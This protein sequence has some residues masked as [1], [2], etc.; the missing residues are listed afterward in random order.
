M[1]T[2][3]TAHYAERVQIGPYTVLEEIARGGHGMVYRAQDAQ[4]RV[5]AL[6]LLLAERAQNRQA[7]ERFQ[8]EVNALGRLRHPHV[9]SILGAGEHEGHPWLA[10]EFVEGESLE[11]RLR[12][13]PL[14]IH[15][16]IRVAQQLAQALSYVHACGVL[17]RDL[18]PGNVL[19]RG[20]EAMLTDFGLVLDEDRSLSR[21]TATGVF[22]GTPGYWSPE[23]ARGETR[24]Q[25][26]FTDVYGLGGVL[27]ACLTGRPPIQAGSLLEYLQFPRFGASD[28]PRALRPEVPAWLEELCLR[29]LREDPRLRPASAEQ[30]A[31]ELVLARG[32]SAR[33]PAAPGAKRW[34]LAL[35]LLSCGALALAAL[36]AGLLLSRP[37]PQPVERVAP[38]DPE[39]APPPPSVAEPVEHD[40]AP[41]DGDDPLETIASCNA[42]IASDPQ[43]AAPFAARG[44]ARAK[45]GWLAAAVED[46]DRALALGTA[47]A[48]RVQRL[49]DDTQAQLAERRAALTAPT[50]EADRARAEALKREGHAQRN[51]KRIREA[52]ASFDRALEL[53]PTQLNAYLNRGLCRVDL[54]RYAE[55]LDDFDH[56]VGLNLDVRSATVL[57]WNRLHAER[58]LIRQTR[59]LLPTVSAEDLRRAQ[60]LFTQGAAH[61]RAGRHAQ[62]IPLFSQAAELNPSTGAYA[63]LGAAK[64]QVGRVEEGLA[65]LDRALDLDLRNG[66]AYYYRGEAQRQLGRHEAAIRDYSASL[67]NKGDEFGALF[68]RGACLNELG[69]Y[70]EAFTDLTRALELDPSYADAHVML[71][72]AQAGL[73]RYEAA[74]ASYDRGLELGLPPAR[75]SHAQRLRAAAQAKLAAGD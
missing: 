67:E 54:R 3:S 39:P 7:R 19:L 33:A 27:Y 43:R 17:H 26:P 64:L 58:M 71:G 68:G 74:L 55:A 34:L 51:A 35:A 8:A 21:I 47:D 22:Q 46:L 23:Q 36:A 11:G 40:P 70:A 24:A 28:P 63:N 16:A 52:A 75:A 42:A 12:R 18:K 62:A 69:R 1:A 50:S 44:A 2:A 13:G 65:D 48:Q 31:R 6:K 59:G 49:R 56:L 15:Q 29:C 32:Q 53:D 60:A 5:V 57:K 38:R 25:G 9:V 37:D 4:G 41:P 20:D 10:L 66:I 14:P 45:L 73:Q 61:Y 30:V 72:L